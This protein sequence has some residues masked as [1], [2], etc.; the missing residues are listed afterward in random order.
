[1]A[2]VGSPIIGPTSSTNI[3]LDQLIPDIQTNVIYYDNDGNPVMSFFSNPESGAL[4]KTD[5][6]EYFW[7]E[8]QLD[9][10]NATLLSAVA[11]NAV[12]G[13]TQVVTIDMPDVVVGQVYQHILSGQTFYILAVANVVPNVQC[14]VTIKPMPFTAGTTAIAANQ[15]IRSLGVFIPEGGFY[16]AP[17]GTKPARLSNIVA[18]RAYSIGITRTQMGS[19]TYAG[20]PYQ[21]AQLHGVKQSKND[22]E[23]MYMFGVRVEEDNVV[24]NNPS[25]NGSWA[26]ALR[27]SLGLYRRI[28][29]NHDLYGGVVSEATFDSTMNTSVFGNRLHGS[30][31]KLGLHGPDIVNDVN[32]FAKNKYKIEYPQN[33]AS[34]YGMD[35]VR[36]RFGSKSVLFLEEREFYEDELRHT[37]LFVDPDHMKV[38][39]KRND[40]IEVYPD[41]QQN[42]EDKVQMSLV[43][44]DGLQTE[45]EQFHAILGWI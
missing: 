1:M 19:P 14:D 18:L 42:N 3:G 21:N 37:M 34:E 4:V 45:C 24:Q 9:Y 2:Y 20:D 10:P 30:S 33:F 32:G 16:P 36:Y 15:L 22:T 11:V 31:T 35:V 44:E 29:T 40:Y 6:V 38:R 26:G 28:T 12:A 13:A 8:N 5:Q 23:R 39:H 41:T 43:F 17:R 25:G 7:Q 27:I